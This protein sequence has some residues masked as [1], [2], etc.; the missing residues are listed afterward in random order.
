MNLHAPTL[1]SW[2]SAGRLKACGLGILIFPEDKIG[3]YGIKWH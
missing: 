3:E 1:F 2:A